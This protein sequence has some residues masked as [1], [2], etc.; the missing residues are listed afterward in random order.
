MILEFIDLWF[1]TPGELITPFLDASLS[2]PP[3]FIST[4]CLCSTCQYFS[5]QESKMSERENK[6]FLH[7][8][9]M[10]AMICISSWILFRWFSHKFICTM[11]SAIG[12]GNDPI[13]RNDIDTWKQC[14]H[15]D[16][17]STIHYPGKIV[18][19]QLYQKNLQPLTLLVCL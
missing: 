16:F 3:E 9:V 5:I 19:W 13:T 8:K 2:S 6:L 18:G 12:I 15:V 17:G 4:M 1:P 10:E 11:V 14:T 7:F